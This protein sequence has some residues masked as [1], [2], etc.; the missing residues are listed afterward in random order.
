VELSAVVLARV[1][2]F[3]EAFDLNPRGKVFFPEIV[4]EIVRRYNFQKFPKTLEEFDEVKGVEFLEGKAASGVIQKVAI[5]NTLLW[6]ETRSN[7]ND[8]KK[9]LE[10]MLN[11]AA[12]KFGFNY[13]SGMIK[14][15]A[16]VSDLTFYS[17]VPLLNVSPALTN[18]AEK[19]SNA[20]SEIFQEPIHYDPISLSV[21][22]DPLSRKYGIAPFSIARRAEALF[23]EN[24]YFSEAPLPTDVH[25][26][27]LEEFESYIK[28][29]SHQER[30]KP[31][32]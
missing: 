27:L 7:T 29:R 32:A 22:H 1:L 31:G 8:S 23:S 15:F 24:K 6:V 17:D 11:W 10:E 14:R 19:T 3:V 4:P 25:L 12:E 5:F 2:G 18:L 20:V 28:L 26:S 30:G 21:G 9:I 16:Y 13:H